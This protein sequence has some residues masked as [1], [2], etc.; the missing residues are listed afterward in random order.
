[1]RL[2]VTS[3]DGA[4]E[5]D[6]AR[7]SI[8]VPNAPVDEDQGVTVK[9]TFPVLRGPATSAFEFEIVIDNETGADS[10][11]SL[12]GEAINGT[13]QA[14]E[15]WI[16]GS[17]QALVGWDIGYIPSF[18]DERLIS[19]VSVGS[20][21]SER[22]DVR[23]QPP[24][25][26]PPG[27]YFVPIRVADDAGFEALTALQVTIR[28]RGEIA[29]STDT[30]LLNIDAIAGEAARSRLRLTN[31]GTAELT[32]VSLTADG[33]QGWEITFEPD[34]V[35]SLPA[36]NLIDVPVNI[37]PV[38]DAI[39]GD[40]L[41]TLRASHPDTHDQVELRVTVAQST[42]W[43]WLG[44]VLVVLVIGGLAGLFWRLGRR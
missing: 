29:A 43:G 30:G 9:A 4:V 21:L 24:R 42:I 7:Y 16:G 3:P 14:L 35:P 34:A 31:F 19:S 32:D 2:R 11:F 23:V 20:A 13:R 5:Y 39:P 26:T 10:S 25:N 1:L 33:P 36:N 15:A 37:V 41:I 38:G 40:Y 8:T 12:E 28:G 27:D 17:G 22:V 18:G 6:S 44:I